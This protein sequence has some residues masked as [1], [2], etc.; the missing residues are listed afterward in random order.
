MTFAE[1][2]KNQKRIKMVPQKITITKGIN[3]LLE[4]LDYWKKA[5]VWTPKKITKETKSWFKYL[6]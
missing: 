4:S 2:K 3:I 1:I 6:K 5:P